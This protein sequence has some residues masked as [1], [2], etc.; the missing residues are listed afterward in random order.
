MNK[1]KTLNL[2]NKFDRINFFKNDDIEIKLF[3]DKADEGIIVVKA[4]IDEFND[5]EEFLFRA[6]IRDDLDELKGLN[7]VK[8]IDLISSDFLLES[9]RYIELKE[10]TFNE[11]ENSFIKKTLNDLSIHIYS[12][13]SIFWIEHEIMDQSLFFITNEYFYYINRSLG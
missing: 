3:I 10:I 1:E 13:K 11:I 12:I 8:S 7:L 2:F 9:D 6:N 4:K 5:I